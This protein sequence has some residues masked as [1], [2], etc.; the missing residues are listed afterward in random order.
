MKLKT[1]VPLQPDETTASFVS[2]LAFANGVLTISE[3]LMDAE[4][5]MAGFLKGDPKVFAKVSDLSGVAVGD[6]MKQACVPHG[7]S[8][9]QL[10]GHDL[11]KQ[12][13]LRGVSRVCPACLRG[14]N[15]LQAHTDAVTAHM[16]ILKR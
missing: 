12:H 10:L 8:R 6:L 9:Y 2:R 11:G 14:D 1:T 15:D 5:T 4:L 16:T 7:L 13:L 3:L